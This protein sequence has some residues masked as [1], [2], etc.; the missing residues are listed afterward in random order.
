M[1]AST[2]ENVPVF[3]VVAPVMDAAGIVVDVVEERVC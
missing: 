1:F 3:W 2:E